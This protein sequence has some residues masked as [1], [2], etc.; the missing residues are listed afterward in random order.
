MRAAESERRGLLA[1]ESLS[2]PSDAP[3]RRGPPSFVAPRAGALMIN[4]CPMNARLRSLALALFA[5]PSIAWAMACGGSQGTTPVCPSAPSSSAAS[6]QGIASPVAPSSPT[7]DDARAFVDRVDQDVR[8]LW[9]ARDEAGWVN[10]NFITDDTEAMAAAAEA[11]T[12]EYFTRTIKEAAKF[13]GLKLPPDVARKL[14]LLK[15][16]Q[17]VPAPSDSA[18]ASELAGDV[19]FMTGA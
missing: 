13:D 12:A 7:A 8:R 18:Q 14:L 16:S 2:T 19:A 3:R 15:I 6:P 17:G 1:M 11:A 10:Q 5:T 9:I 4:R